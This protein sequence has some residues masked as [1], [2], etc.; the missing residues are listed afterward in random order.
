MI[1][2][3][4]AGRVIYQFSEQQPVDELAGGRLRESTEADKPVSASLA[5]TMP[6]PKG[7][8]VNNFAAFL[9]I[10][11]GLTFSLDLPICRANNIIVRDF[12]YQYILR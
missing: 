4:A 10:C 3:S 5:L 12:R 1:T 11:R 2:I 8:D 7:G 6:Q 9:S